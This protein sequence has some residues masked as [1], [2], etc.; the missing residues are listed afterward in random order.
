MDGDPVCAKQQK[1]GHKTA[2]DKAEEQAGPEN[3]LYIL[4]LAVHAPCRDQL[5][6]GERQTVGRQ[7]QPNVVNFVGRVVA[8]SL[9]AD[10]AGHRNLVEKSD[11]ADDDT[12]CGENASLYQEVAGVG[13]FLIVTHT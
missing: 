7:D 12:G 3:T 10:G 8:D 1:Q 4:N 9:I 6:N 5:G 2:C 11:K 13:F